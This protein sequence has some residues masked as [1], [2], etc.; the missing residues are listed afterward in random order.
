MRSYLRAL[1]IFVAN[2]IIFYFPAR[3]SEFPCEMDNIVMC[4]NVTAR[5]RWRRLR[6]EFYLIAESYDLY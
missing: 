1:F 5:W 4:F 2:F 6:S 3:I